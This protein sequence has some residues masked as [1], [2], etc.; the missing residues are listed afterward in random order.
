[1]ILADVSIKRPV[2][3]TMLNVVLIVFGLFSYKKLGIDQ[4]PNIDFPVVTV[5]VTYPG[6]DPKTVEQKVLQPLEKGL[7]GIE[8]LEALNATAFPNFGQ[9]VLRFKL[10]RNGD[11]AAQDVRDKMSALASQLPTEALAPVVAKFDIGGAPII[12]M[13]LSADSL[14]Y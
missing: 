4:F 12:T 2:F 6:A 5:Q 8:G 14:P 11:K 1:M 3:A 10:E 9:V 7:N 13:T